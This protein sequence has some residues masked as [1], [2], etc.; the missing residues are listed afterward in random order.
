M[1][2]QLIIIGIVAILICVR[3]SGCLTQH[4][5]ENQVSNSL[6]VERNKFVGTW[7][8][9][10]GSVTTTWNLFSNGTSS[11]ENFTGTWNLTDSKLVIN[12]LSTNYLFTYTFNYTFS[13]NNRTLILISS[14]GYTPVIYT[15]QTD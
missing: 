7:T 4:N 2:K 14:G 12:L 1:K 6:N 3:L 15:K 13:N 8:N 10:T 5:N 11:L 9:T